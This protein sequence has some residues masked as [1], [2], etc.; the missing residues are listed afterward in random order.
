M[1]DI[2]RLGMFPFSFLPTPLYL[3]HFFLL[4]HSYALIS[5]C[6]ESLELKWVILSDLFVFGLQ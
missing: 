3:E 2:A 4:S 1:F 5:P 6:L